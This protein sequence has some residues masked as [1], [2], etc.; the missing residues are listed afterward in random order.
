[1]AAKTTIQNTSKRTPEETA[2]LKA[3][4]ERFQTERPGLPELVAEY[5]Y[6]EP[7]PQVDYLGLQ[8]A[9]STL[10]K[11]REDA[12]LS[13]ADISERT[14]MDKATLSR[15]E[16]G[17]QINPTVATLARYAKA[18]GKR[19]EWAVGDALPAPNH[20]AQPNEAGPSG[21]GGPQ[22]PPAVPATPKKKSPF[23]ESLITAY[24][25]VRGAELHS[26]D[27]VIADPDLDARFLERCR[28]LGA[29]GSD[30]ELN[31]RLFNARKAKLLAD[32]L[33]AKKFVIP[34]P[35]L[36]QFL[37]ASE[38]ALR[39]LQDERSDPGGQLLSLD[40]IICDPELAK[41]FDK[42]AG[43]LAPGFSPL[44]YRWGAIGL[45]KAAGRIRAEAE[46]AEQ[47]RFDMLG[48][49]DKI[50]TGELPAAQG[51]YLISAE[52][53]PLFVGNTANIRQR[54]ER[55]IQIGE[56][57]ILPGWMLSD[58]GLKD[59]TLGVSPMPG[60]E[61]HA[62][63]VCEWGSRIALQPALNYLA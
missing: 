58:L 2:R 53:R 23:V 40:R 1:M 63:D 32:V 51:L 20:I 26:T 29:A 50:S 27:R 30:F 19:V 62:I 45:R 7:L 36:D 9:I 14:G 59:L 47:P 55:H 31:H 4:R 52:E 41:E 28:S 33:T 49:V 5:G 17:R 61:V 46:R 56:G 22:N 10:K 38:I 6:N 15:L 35:S 57:T 34:R 3:I 37:F 8:Q 13:L 60:S 43:R 11:A 39:M 24:V 12:G 16:T 54:V 25:D 48:R 42:I 21:Q 18:V 44:Y